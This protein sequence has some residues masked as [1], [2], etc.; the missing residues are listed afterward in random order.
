MSLNVCT[1]YLAPLD[2]FVDW[3]VL[4]SHASMRT[5]IDG[6]GD[7][8]RVS[9]STIPP[10]KKLNI[11]QE[12]RNLMAPV[13]YCDHMDPQFQ[14]CGGYWSLWQVY[15]LK[16]LLRDAPVRMGVYKGQCMN[17]CGSNCPLLFIICIANI[18]QIRYTSF[19]LLRCCPWLWES[20]PSQV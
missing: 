19:A 4:Y 11:V 5:T 2:S 7:G 20:I 17:R 13:I 6:Y 9:W 10:G 18:P 12:P 16:Y 3:W 14:L 15:S 8:L 1:N